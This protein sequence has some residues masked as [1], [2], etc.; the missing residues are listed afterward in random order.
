MQSQQIPHQ[1][2]SQGYCNKLPQGSRELKNNTNIFSLS[3]GGQKSEIRLAGPPSPCGPQGSPLPAPSWRCGPWEFPGGA[4]ATRPRLRATGPS[5]FCVSF[6]RT[7]AIGFRVLPNPGGSLLK[8][9]NLL[10]K[11]PFP[12]YD[13]SH[14]FWETFCRGHHSPQ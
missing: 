14:K 7:L 9:L 13:C 11:D 5:L 4:A 1:I 8:I 6:L 10:C 3:L 12:K 2:P